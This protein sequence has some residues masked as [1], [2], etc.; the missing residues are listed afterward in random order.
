MNWH[1]KLILALGRAQDI[2]ALEYPKHNKKPRRSGVGVINSQKVNPGTNRILADRPIHPALRI[3]HIGRALSR[4][5]LLVL[6]GCLFAHFDQL[7]H[8]LE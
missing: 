6:V 2:T 5:I 7:L 4:G 3:N 1:E 8:G